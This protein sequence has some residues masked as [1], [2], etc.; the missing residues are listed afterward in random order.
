LRWP[1]T[2]KNQAEKKAGKFEKTQYLGS[3]SGKHFNDVSR[4]WHHIINTNSPTS[5]SPTENIREPRDN[6][7]G[8]NHPGKSLWLM[9]PRTSISF[10]R[11]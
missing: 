3:Q 8:Q 1:D 10:F 2:S 4:C 6:L 9:F 5:P 11:A 7:G